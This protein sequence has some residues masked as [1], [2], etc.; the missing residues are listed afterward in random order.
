MKGKFSDKVGYDHQPACAAPPFENQ[1]SQRTMSPSTKSQ[2]ERALSRGNAMS[3]ARIISGTRKLAK[4]AR[5]GTTM[6]KIIVVP[7]I[8]RTSLYEFFVRTFSPA[9][10]RRPRR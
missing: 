2:E 8:V 1:L 5:I 3:R 7:C 9:V 10:A 6:R 4:P